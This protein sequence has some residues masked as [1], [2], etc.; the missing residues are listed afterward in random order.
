MGRGVWSYNHSEP[1]PK[2]IIKLKQLKISEKPLKKQQERARF[3]KI[4]KL[5]NHL[6]LR[7]GSFEPHNVQC[8]HQVKSRQWSASLASYY[9]LK[10]GSK[11]TNNTSLIDIAYLSVHISHLLLINETITNSRNYGENKQCCTKN[12]L[13]ILL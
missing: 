11:A 8:C 12:S 3:R 5:K 13:L 9:L 6:L 10:S 4:Y 7:K 1:Y 2:K